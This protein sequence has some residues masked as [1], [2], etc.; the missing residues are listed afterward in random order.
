ML[1]EC[2]HFF[3]SEANIIITPLD[4]LSSSSHFPLSI[5]ILLDMLSQSSH[6]FLSET[7]MLAKSGNFSCLKPMLLFWICYQRLAIFL[8]ETSII[9]TLLFWICWQSLV[10]FLTWNE[11]YNNPILFAESSHFSYMKRYSNDRALIDMVS[12]SSQF[13]YQKPI[14]DMLS[15][16]VIL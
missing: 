7:N 12:E 11:Y 3:L 14:L 4:M 9:I 5:P 8:S 16:L 13:S 10:I 6:F 1:S 15:N 2:S